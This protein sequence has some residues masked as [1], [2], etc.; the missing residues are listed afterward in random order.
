MF[1]S[2]FMTLE[3]STIFN[4]KYMFLSNVKNCMSPF[5]DTFGICVF[6]CLPPTSYS[7]RKVSSQLTDRGQRHYL[8]WHLFAT[9]KYHYSPTGSDSAALCQKIGVLW[10]VRKKPHKRKIAKGKR[11]EFEKLTSQIVY[12][13]LIFFFVCLPGQN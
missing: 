10:A 5:A 6:R 9:A 4:V 12:L 7:D 3:C 1:P 8:L 11:R 2:S 13:V